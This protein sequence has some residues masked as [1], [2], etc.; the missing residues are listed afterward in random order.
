M[1]SGFHDAQARCTWARCYM[2]STFHNF[3]RHSGRRKT[4]SMMTLVRAC[5][6]RTSGVLCLLRGMQLALWSS[7]RWVRWRISRTLASARIV[8]QLCHF[9]CCCFFFSLLREHRKKEK[10]KVHWRTVVED[11][12]TTTTT[13]TNTRDSHQN[14]AF[15]W[16]SS[17]SSI[18]TLKHNQTKKERKRQIEGSCCPHASA[19]AAV[20]SLLFLNQTDAV[21]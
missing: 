14:R 11:A 16:T 20:P 1:E 8:T 21:L 2:Y 15:K 10:R 19:L 3:V 12:A 7:V 9:C 4:D 5:C 18:C 6:T 13:T 17:L